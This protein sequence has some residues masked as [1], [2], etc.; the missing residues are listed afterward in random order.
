MV[1]LHF[2]RSFLHHGSVHHRLLGPILP[3]PLRHHPVGLSSFVTRRKTTI[4]V[5]LKRRQVSRLFLRLCVFVGS[6]GIRIVLQLL[7]YFYTVFTLVFPFPLLH[8]RNR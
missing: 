4:P 7:C 2:F 1:R 6:Q 3:H 5:E 8:C